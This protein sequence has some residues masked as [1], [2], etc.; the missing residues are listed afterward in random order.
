MHGHRFRFCPRRRRAAFTLIELLVVV[1]IIAIIAAML[2]PALGKAREKARIALCV[3]NAGQMAMA[4]TLYADDHETHL[5]V[6]GQPVIGACP[7]N[8][9]WCAP[10][11]RGTLYGMYLPEV[12]LFSCPLNP[13][14]TRGEGSLAGAY[15]LP[16]SYM[17]NGRFTLNAAGSAPMW[18]TGQPP[19]ASARDP[20]QLILLG[21]GGWDVD[22]S[23]LA[24]FTQP[25]RWFWTH[26]DV[27]SAYVFADSH[28]E[29]LRPTDTVNGA[30]F[31]SPT[32]A[33]ANAAW[34]TTLQ[35]EELFFSQ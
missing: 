1:A 25:G 20:H 4:L 9:S 27:K 15:N 16:L 21:E 3:N 31:W 22:P 23:Y 5:P 12:K 32:G 13:S 8:G 30:N 26:S 7:G 10:T 24:N 33:A 11:W 35:T 29:R 28:V 18:H 17:C 34:I 6:A 2:L 19:L 14:N